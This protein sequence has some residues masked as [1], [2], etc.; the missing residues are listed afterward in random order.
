MDED[1]AR[2]RRSVFGLIAAVALVVLG[3]WLGHMLY[4][5]LQYERCVEERRVCDPISTE[6]GQ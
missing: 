6:P 3:I 2:Y 5:N 4:K 1:Q